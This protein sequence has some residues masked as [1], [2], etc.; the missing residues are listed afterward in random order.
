MDSGIV[1][2]CHFDENN[3]FELKSFADVAKE[4]DLKKIALLGGHGSNNIPKLISYLK[5]V[6]LEKLT[7]YSFVDSPP[8]RTLHL[9]EKGLELKSKDNATTFYSLEKL[10]YLF[11]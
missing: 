3:F 4:K 11:E 2:Y 5:R 7:D 9:S 1:H 6:G 10:K 8:I